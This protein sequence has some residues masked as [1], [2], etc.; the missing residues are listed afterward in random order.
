M[1]HQELEEVAG[2]SLKPG[3]WSRGKKYVNLILVVSCAFKFSGLWRLNLHPLNVFSFGSNELFPTDCLCNYLQ[4][5]IN[6]Q[7]RMDFNVLEEQG[8]KPHPSAPSSTPHII[9]SFLTLNPQ[10][11]FH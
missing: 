11:R 3:G 9:L 4:S 1:S 10:R 7:P 2:E 5:E 6:Q 8:R